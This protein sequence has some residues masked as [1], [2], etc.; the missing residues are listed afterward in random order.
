M[1]TK[2][3]L[4]ALLVI[5]VFFVVMPPS[6]IQGVEKYT[7]DP[8]YADS[9]ATTV[10]TPD[11]L[12]K[13]IQATQTALSRQIGKC[14]YCIETTS[15]SLTGD[16]YSGRFLFVVLPGA[17]GSQW[18]SPYGIGVDSTVDGKTYS[19]SSINLQSNETIDQMDPYEQFKSGSDIQNGTL[20][21]LAQLQ[22]ALNSS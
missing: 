8:G 16:T 20:P 11:A 9:D 19:V 7:S 10:V 2:T 4:L 22:S 1:E 15:I 13:V 5:A 6:K 21:T 3:I 12:Q 18:S 17:S 14:T